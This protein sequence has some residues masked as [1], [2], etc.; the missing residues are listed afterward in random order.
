M[1]KS[2]CFKKLN[3]TLRDVHIYWYASFS[4]AFSLVWLIPLEACVMVNCLC[5]DFPA[6]YHSGFKEM[7]THLHRQPQAR[8]SCMWQPGDSYHFLYTLIF[9]R[10]R[11]KP[12]NQPDSPWP[13]AKWVGWLLIGRPCF[14][15]SQNSHIYYTMI[16]N[17]GNQ[18]FLKFRKCSRSK[19]PVSV[20][21][22]EVPQ[23]IHKSTC[24]DSEK[25]LWNRLM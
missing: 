25:T 10:I 11:F 2:Y 7:G 13:I 8:V 20:P 12:I 16:L 21:G 24:Q 23:K 18:V 4:Q 15:P 5:L 19:R 1:I 9:Q 14:L 6:H 17:N 22:G 3:V